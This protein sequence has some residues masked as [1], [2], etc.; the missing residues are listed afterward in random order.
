ME[1]LTGIIMTLVIG[2]TVLVVG[3][4]LIQK[5]FDE[6]RKNADKALDVINNLFE[7]MPDMFKKVVSIEE[8]RKQK[9]MEDWLK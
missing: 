8:E 5:I 2:F 6:S 3:A 1:L 9:D 7:K 4:A